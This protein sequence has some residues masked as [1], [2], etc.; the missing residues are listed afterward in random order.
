VARSDA[1]LQR[2]ALRVRQ[3][4]P[5]PER[6][7]RLPVAAA[8]RTWRPRLAWRPVYGLATAAAMLLL[9]SLLVLRPGGM[10]DGRFQT[11]MGE[12]DRLVENALPEAYLHI[13]GENDLE[14]D[15][16][17]LDFLIP[18]LDDHL[19]QAEEP[20]GGSPC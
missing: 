12:I 16:G 11:M 14:S 10:G 17:F 3:A 15:E 8:H 4:A 5:E 18:P 7:F 2:L 1:A 13:A 6:P 20:V 9:V 19:S